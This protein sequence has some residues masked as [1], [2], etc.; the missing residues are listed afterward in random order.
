M[1]TV[2]NVSLETFPDRS[3]YTRRR[4]VIYL[5]L[6]REH[7]KSIFRKASVPLVKFFC[8]IKLHRISES[9]LV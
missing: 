5:D 3:F 7:K 6:T 1:R 2:A 4:F 8:R 9:L